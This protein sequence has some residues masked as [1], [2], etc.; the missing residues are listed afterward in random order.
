MHYWEKVITVL[1]VTWPLTTAPVIIVNSGATYLDETDAW[2]R[3]H[4]QQP[5]VIHAMLLAAQTNAWRLTRQ[6]MEDRAHLCVTPCCYVLTAKSSCAI[7][8][9]GWGLN[10]HTCGECYCFNCKFTYHPKEDR[11]LCYMHSINAT[12]CQQRTPCQFIFHD[13]KSMLLNSG[14]H[15]PNLIVAQSIC[16]HYSVHVPTC[17][18]CGS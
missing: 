12:K 9:K 4:H 5:C 14:T 17:S 2:W 3:M 10:K 6:N 8:K 11:H 13:F 18:T 15:R 1:T 16:K 7:T